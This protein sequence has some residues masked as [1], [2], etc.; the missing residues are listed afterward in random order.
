MNRVVKETYQAA[1]RERGLLE[2]NNQWEKHFER[3]FDFSMS[4]EA[5]GVVSDD[6]I[7]LLPI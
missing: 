3:S 5:E 7:I 1:C 6:I 2:N 4:F